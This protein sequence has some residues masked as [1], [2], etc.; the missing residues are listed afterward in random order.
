MAKLFPSNIRKVGIFPLSLGNQ[1]EQ[2]LRIAL[3]RLRAFGVDFI[4]PEP[5]CPEFRYMAA[6]DQERARI[7]NSLLDNPEV[8]VLFALRG[9]FGAARALEY[10]N[11]E[12]LFQ[13]NIPVIGYSD[14][15][16]FLLAAYAKGYRNCISGAMAESTFGTPGLTDEEVEQCR[17][18]LYRCVEGL[19]VSVPYPYK[20]EIIKDGCVTAPIVPA[21]LMLLVS[22]I[23][24]PWMPDLSGKILLLE[25]IGTPALQIDRQLTQLKQCGILEKAAGI[26]FGTFINGEDERYQPE[27]FR[28]FGQL[29]KGPAFYGFPFGHST[30]SA[31]IRV[32]AE[33]TLSVQNGEVQIK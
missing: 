23:G 1:G 28:E 13:R 29:T 11:W 9:G 19:P 8:D 15:T 16:A 24:T 2:F 18:A 10:I 4:M 7:F 5:Q 25:G 21:N 30:P 14:M 33:I 26:V 3:N 12:K 20:P 6:T 22:M 27:L 31:S 17:M 32:G